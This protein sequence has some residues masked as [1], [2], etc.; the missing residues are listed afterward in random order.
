VFANEILTLQDTQKNAGTLSVIVIGEP[1]QRYG[2]CVDRFLGE[3]DLVVRPLDPRLG[4]IPNISA[5]ALSEKGD[6]ILILDVT[7]ML[8][9][10]AKVAAGNTGAG[11]RSATLLSA[12]RPLA[13]APTLQASNPKHAPKH[14][15]RHAPKRVLVVD[16]SMTVRA[17]EKKLLQSRGY[18][19]DIAVDGAEG[20]NALNLNT[21]DLVITDVDMP[22]MSGI[23]LIEKMRA[24][25]STK[26]LPVIVVSYKDRAE[27][28]LAGLNAGANYYLTKSSF[29]DDGLINAV[30]DL[31][32]QPF[33]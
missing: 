3:R 13:D 4:K 8:R 10:A 11:G 27:D 23:E 15:L 33:D 30:V 12:E 21:Y 16:D 25:D 5:A 17:M 7:D 2:L 28:Q 14:A 32:G 1:G 22:R 18:A 24:Q 6:P 31:I 20:W 9:S 29:H 26:R 19:V